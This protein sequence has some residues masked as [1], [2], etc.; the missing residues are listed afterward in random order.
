MRAAAVLLAALLAASPLAAAEEEPS[1]PV[2]A[3]EIV[4]TGVQPG[5]RMW[6]VEDA[7]SEVWI[8]GTNRSLP[9]K[10]KWDTSLVERVLTG[11][12]LVVTQVE[13][14]VSPF[15][16]VDILLTDRELFFLPKKQTLASVL[17]PE[18]FARLE[19]ARKQLEV[20]S[21]RFQRLRPP[22]A[23]GMLLGRAVERAALNGKPPHEQVENLARRRGVKVRPLRTYRG[24]DFI[25]NADK[26][27]PAAES[28]CL[29]ATLAIIE[30]GM[31][32]VR[33]YADAWA[34]GDVAYLRGHPPPV[35]L[36]RCEQELTDSVDFFK[37]A[38]DE[39]NAA[40]VQ[41][42]EAGLAAPGKRLILI[43]IDDAI[44]PQT[45]LIDRLRARG[46]AVE[47][48]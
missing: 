21:P 23:G 7:D 12:N 3:E 30:K 1:T 31:P 38:V 46:Y 5:P 17:E 15:R 19:T 18:L 45:G 13:V 43:A 25:R 27:T 32:A 16:V 29:A 9:K 4:V 10:V 41:E 22:I 47:G 20:E 24:R 35:E 34:R 26:V 8:L 33:A 28:A 2:L 44:T 48:P 11:A 6:V 42:V 37:E 14:K 40:Y 39:V 36:K